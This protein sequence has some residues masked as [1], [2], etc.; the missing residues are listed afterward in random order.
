[1]S[2]IPQDARERFREAL[3]A[4]RRSSGLTQADV[5][6]R[7]GVSPSFVSKC[8][9][10][11]R[12]LDVVEFLRIAEVL[13]VNAH[14]I[15]RQI[16]Y[17][18]DYTSSGNI[19]EEL[20]LTTADVTTVVRDNP[21]LRGM[22]MTYAA[23]QKLWNAWLPR[24][25]ISYIGKP[26][27]IDW[28]NRGGHIIEYQKERFFIEIKSVQPPTVVEDGNVW[29]GKAQVDY[30]ERRSVPLDDG[31]FLDTTL[32]A[33]RECDVLAVNCFAFGEGW[34]FVFAKNDDLPRSRYRR[35][36]IEVRNQLIASLVP[37]SWPPEPPFS[38]NLL[39]VMDQLTANRNKLKR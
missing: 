18:D 36:P 30:G 1:M 19:L 29:R 26:D 7:L 14:H 21:S 38:D 5:A 13:G 23:E 11:E 15:I 28:P 4:A 8:E 35:Y 6:A 39:T 22:L 31:S 34:N 17:G 12:R 33:V 24:N 32:L 2:I 3:A 10:G 37:V 16:T 25:K 20:M 27:D 9:M